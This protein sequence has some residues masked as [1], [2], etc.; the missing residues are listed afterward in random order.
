PRTCVLEDERILQALADQAVHAITNAQL[1]AQ[2]RGALHHEQEA[3]RQK[4]VFLASASHELRTPLNI[5]LGYI[6][7]ICEGVIGQVDHAAAETLGRAR[8]AVHQLITLLNDLLDLPRIERA[9][10]PLH[11]APLDLHERSHEKKTHR[12]QA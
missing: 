11:Q 8:K 1:Y 3:N 2:L 6:D 9:E 7:L 10:F 12:A 5:V 4:S